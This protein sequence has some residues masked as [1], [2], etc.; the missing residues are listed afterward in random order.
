MSKIEVTSKMPQDIAKGLQDSRYERV[1]GTIRD[2]ESK[3]TLAWLR[4][5]YEIGAPI[6]SDVLSLA[7]SGSA[8][9][10][11]LNLAISTMQFALIMKQLNLIEQQLKQVQ[12]VLNI[13]DYKIDLAFYANFRAA[14]ALA[15][16]SFTMTSSETRRIC[17]MQAISR[18]LEAEH[19]YTHLVATEIANGSQVADDY[20]TTL[21]LAYVTEVKCYLELEELDTAHHRMQEGLAVLKPY[22][23]RHINT[24]LTSNPAAYLHPSLKDQIDLRRLTKVYQWLNPG[25]D[26]TAMF[27]SQRE[28]LFE[29]ANTS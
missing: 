11:P 21:C 8:Q 23:E 10:N 7:A 4:E 3:Q 2:R 16:N 28:N 18:F 14:L 20:L 1:G 15:N 19:H 27:E 6:A 29:L 5:A 13:I 22:F 26:E 24:L 9:A 17:A 12:E 25:M